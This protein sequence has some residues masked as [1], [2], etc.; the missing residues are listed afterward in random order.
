MRV[1]T[2]HE[3]Y[4]L[5]CIAIFV[6]LSFATVILCGGAG[7]L[8]VWWSGKQAPPP[9]YIGDP[10]RGRT[11]VARYGCTSCHAGVREEPQGAVGP[12]LTAVAQRAYIAGRFPNTQI[13]MIEWIRHP[14]EVK[15]GT[16]MPDLGV[17]ERDA[18]D[19]SAY[20]ATLR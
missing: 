1:E 7:L 4:L 19:L 15:P 10:G 3:R 6:A 5:G 18:R 8:W 17:S 20:L 13:R 12:P 14:Q 9:G 11:L 2:P 16:A